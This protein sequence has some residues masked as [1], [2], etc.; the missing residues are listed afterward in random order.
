MTK[1]L[2]INEFDQGIGDSPHRG[3]ALM[4]RVDLEAYPGA[5]KVKG[6]LSSLFATAYSNTFTAVA[7]TDVCTGASFTTNANT[8]GTPVVLTTTGTLPAGLSLSTTYFIIRVDQGAGTF[9][10]ATTIANANAGTAI[11]ITDTG[12][13]THTMATRDPGTINHIVKD[14]RN[15]NRFF[16][17]SNGRVW[18]L[19]SGA[20]RCHLLDGNTL[21]SGSGNGIVTFLNSDSTATYLFVFRN[22]VIDII[23]I[24]AT[25]DLETPVWTTAWKTMNTAAATNNRHHALIGQDNIIY[26]TDGRYIGSI[27]ELTVFVPATAS[28]YTF[29]SQAL[30]TP[31]NEVLEHLEELGVNLLAAGGTY[32]KIYPWDRLADSYTLPISVPENGVKRIKNIG[33]LIYI[34]AGTWG[35]IYLSQGSYAKFFKKI[36][37]QVA[38]NSG[39]LQ[40]NP[41]AWGG[42]DAVNGALLFGASVLTSGNSGA[43]L[44]YPDGRIII[45]QIPLTAGNATAFE[46]TDNFY[47]IGYASG[48]DE[49]T[50]TRYANFEGIVQSPFYRVSTKTEKATYSKLEVVTAKPA[51]SG[52]IRVGYRVDTSS[53]FTTLETF[54]TDSA[55][56]IFQKDDIGLIDI[57]NIQIQ[58]EFHG[59]VEILEVRL[60]P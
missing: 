20:S 35:N 24:F 42:I 32:N 44:L 36:P 2:I 41:V 58:L 45:D 33:N 50:S 31:Q 6:A 34:L 37:D 48:A 11:N 4:T 26:Y 7:A 59:T 13:G 9:K 25:A 30:D 27:K 43:Y 47:Y 18:Y 51:T 49:H 8:T 19:I 28:T 40:S 29:T 3:F 39:T 10:L 23:N 46:V 16:H 38:N 55:T 15:S 21:T 1:P 53:S 22:A 14:P 12:S 52:S 57:E 5:V 56:I 60:I 54:A 17:D